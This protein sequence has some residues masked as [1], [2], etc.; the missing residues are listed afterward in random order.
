MLIT[1]TCSGDKIECNEIG[2]TCIMYGIEERG[3]KDFGWEN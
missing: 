3:V 1:Q 2:G